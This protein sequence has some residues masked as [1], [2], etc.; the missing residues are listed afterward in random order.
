[1]TSDK[2]HVD[3][4][5]KDMETV[6]FYHDESELLCSATTGVIALYTKRDNTCNSIPSLS[7]FKF[8][9]SSA[10]KHQLKLFTEKFNV[11]KKAPIHQYNTKQ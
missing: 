3:S 9:S 4:L 1:M 5:N 11:V 6:I 10:I 8:I 2:T 7:I